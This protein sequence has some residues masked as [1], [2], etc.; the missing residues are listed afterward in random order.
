MPRKHFAYALVSRQNIEFDEWM[1]ELRAQHEGAVPKDHVGRVA[2]TILRKC[3]PKQY[4]LSH[5]TIVASV[6]TCAPRGAKTGRMMNRGVQIDV[7]WPDYRIKP[8]CQEIVN[9]NGDAWERS[10]LLS[11]YRTFIGAPNYLEHIQLPELS[12]GF[13]V[14]AIARDLGK[15]CY[16][17]ILVATDRKHAVLVQ[18]ILAGEISAMSMGCVS[19]FTRCTKCGN[20]AVDDSQL[21]PCVAFEGKGAKFVD[22]DGVEGVISELIGHV[23]VPNSNQFI[24]ASWVRNPAFRGAVRRNILNPDNQAIAAMLDEANKVYEIRRDDINLDG[25]KKAASSRFAQGEG[26]DQGGS[27]EP[28]AEDQAA[29]DD[30]D[31]GAPVDEPEGETAEGDDAG[32]ADPGSTD[33]LDK[34]L[35]KAQEMIVQSLVK[36]LED[37]LAPKPED[38]GSVTPAAPP[39]VSA[40]NDNLVRSSDPFADRLKSLFPA[41]SPIVGWAVK[42][43]RVTAGGPE[44]IRRS[45]M[46]PRDLIILSWIE[47]RVAARECNP[48]LYNV[49]MN[50]GPLKSFPSETSFL[51]A[52]RHRLGRSLSAEE[53]KFFSRKGRIASLVEGF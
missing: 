53:R 16:V 21:C 4:L 20:I 28:P 19:L 23:S 37:K 12:K 7:R 36:G 25:M 50:V 39:S 24:E 18:D 41:G 51:A 22:Q 13:I 48:A 2:K 9:N 1:E 10:L 5:S 49:A 11:S 40:G 47:D 52:C 46:T 6:D 35:E 45:G 44:S 3:D 26:Q 33:S 31:L 14:D 42:A 29:D 34:L 15:T 43:R 17:D 8:E 32:V 38:V 27:D 30:G